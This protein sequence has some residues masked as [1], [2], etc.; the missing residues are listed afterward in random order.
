[1]RVRTLW[2]AGLMAAGLTLA[3]AA[4]RAQDGGSAPASW[5]PQGG[6]LLPDI[7]S[8]RAQTYDG[9]VPDPENP[10]PLGHNPAN[11][12][13][14]FVGAEFIFWRQTNILEH[15]PIAYRGFWDSDGSVVG[16]PV[17]P[18]LPGTFIGSGLV[19]L[20]AKDAGGPGTYQPGLRTTIGYAWSDG[21]SIDIR[22][23]WLAKAQY[24][25]EATIV[26]TPGGGFG[27]ALE[28]SFIS[29]PVINFSNNFAGP[30]NIPVA[31]TFILPTTTTTV[32]VRK[33][34]GA[35]DGALYGIWDGADVMTISFIQR[36][37]SLDSTFR[38]P[39]LYND[40]CG[41]RCY[42]LIGPRF[43]WIWERFYWRTVNE[44]ANGQAGPTDV[45]I[46]TNIVS[47][48]MYGVF[49]GLGNE[50]YIGHGLACN[51]DVEAAG[52]LD[53]VKER[54][55]YE[56]GEK[57]IPGEIKR[58]VTQ[59]TFVPQFTATANVTW[60]PIESVELRLG[61]DLMAFANTIAAPKPVTFNVGGLDP[62]WVH[63]WRFFDGF[64]AGLG[65]QF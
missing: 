52:L 40:D 22:W 24:L 6:P 28:N 41:Y 33:I 58:A 3:P 2:L 13:G 23:L 57:D 19:A 46:Y 49:V 32:N 26:S 30:G 21:T 64:Q 12:G 1:M 44:D 11:R 10:L 60:F 31:H 56:L 17:N 55:K 34:P 16:T 25:H 63:R 36:T 59:Y 62:A 14:F 9:E 8:V 53:V 35:D 50:W 29:A 5:P 37:E 65:I 38:V 18:A 61:Y 27:P 15:Q 54:A 39:I 47:N 20:D 4:A 48:R 42:G 45:A 51:I 7:L 43:F